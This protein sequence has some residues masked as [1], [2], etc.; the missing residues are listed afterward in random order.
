MKNIKIYPIN[1][2]LKR[3]EREINRFRRLFL[4]QSADNGGKLN[5]TCVSKLFYLFAL[6]A[7]RSKIVKRYY[8]IYR[9][10]SFSNTCWRE[11]KCWMVKRGVHFFPAV[12]SHS[13]LISSAL[14]MC[15]QNMQVF[16]LFFLLLYK[17]AIKL[18]ERKVQSSIE[19][20]EGRN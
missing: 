10:W 9:C 14:N 8:E 5:S 20:D 12:R 11:G 4:V 18:K 17:A 2:P 7:M 16:L 15:R 13:N 3:A 1:Y 19:K 6:F